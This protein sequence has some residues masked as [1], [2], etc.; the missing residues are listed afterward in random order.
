[1]MVAAT[2]TVMIRTMIHH[3]P[4]IATEINIDGMMEVWR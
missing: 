3:Y 4:E 2:L 1:M